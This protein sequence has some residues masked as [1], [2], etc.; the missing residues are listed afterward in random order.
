MK[1]HKLLAQT[2]ATHKDSNVV[3]QTAATHKDQW[4]GGSEASG[5]AA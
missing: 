5:E 1:S 3:E 4:R 2:A